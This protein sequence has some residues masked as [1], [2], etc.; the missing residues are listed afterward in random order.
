LDIAVFLFASIRPTDREKTMTR[1]LSATIALPDW[2][3]DAVPAEVVCDSAEERMSFAI[4]LAERNI[5]AGTGGPFG[6]AIFETGSGRM[7]AAGVNVVVASSMAIAHAEMVAMALA[8]AAIGNHDLAF[9]GETE[10]VATTEPCAMCLG[11]VGWSGVT[12]LVCGARD[13]DARAVGFDEGAKPVE[14]VAD[15]AAAGI[16][17]TRDVLRSEAA[18]VLIRYAESGGVIYNGRAAFGAREEG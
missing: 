18:A 7:V 14:W 11:A 5:A 6:A 10:L 17:V 2:W 9:L 8:G 13:E 16:S 3:E 12:S 15:L 4:G 1:P